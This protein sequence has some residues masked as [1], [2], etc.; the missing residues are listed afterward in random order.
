[1]GCGSQCVSTQPKVKGG[2][3]SR[4]SADVNLASFSYA[5]NVCHAPT[6]YHPDHQDG[7]FRMLIDIDLSRVGSGTR[8]GRNLKRKNRS[9]SLS[10]AMCIAATTRYAIIAIHYGPHRLGL[11]L[12]NASLIAPAG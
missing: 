5:H 1:M 12:P 8:N 4:T 11:G 10:Y 7:G 3:A 9:T 2:H 6:I